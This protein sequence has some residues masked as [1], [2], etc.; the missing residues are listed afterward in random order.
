MISRLITLILVLFLPASAQAIKHYQA[1]IE[2]SQW[3]NQTSPVKCELKHQIPSYGH[4]AFVYASDGELAFEVKPLLPAVKNSVAN[5]VSSPPFWRHGNDVELGQLSLEKGLTPIYVSGEL[6][7]RLMYELDAGMMPT[8]KYKDFFNEKD[9]IHI[10]LSAI[11]FKNEL[12]DF[13]QCVS[14]LISF[15]TLQNETIYFKTNSFQLS[16]SDKEKLEALALYASYNPEIKIY[17]EGHTDSRGTR[18][19]NL[20]LSKRR[21]N[22]V[23]DYFVSKGVASSQIEFKSFGEKHLLAKKQRVI[24]KHASNRRVEVTFSRAK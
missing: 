24:G 13:Q 11:N 19:Y 1:S 12:P 9:E 10:S 4:G 7:T 15:G 14:Q 2:Q 22:V 23:K 18:R 5:L 17:I 3:T 8:F 16:K 6:A 20:Q 21:T